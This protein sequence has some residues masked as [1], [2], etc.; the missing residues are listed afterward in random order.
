MKWNEIEYP[1]CDEGCEHYVKYYTAFCKAGRVM[2]IGT[3]NL[4]KKEGEK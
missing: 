1:E 3:C 2:D 4:Y